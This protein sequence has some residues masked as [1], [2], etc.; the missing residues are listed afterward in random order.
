[1]ALYDIQALRRAICYVD[2]CHW[3]TL[4]SD[5][6]LFSP[7]LGPFHAGNCCVFLVHTIRML[8]TTEG[9]SVPNHLFHAVCFWNAVWCNEIILLFDTEC[10]F[11]PSMRP[12]KA[13]VLDSHSTAMFVLPYALRLGTQGSWQFSGSYSAQ[14]T[15]SLYYKSPRHLFRGFCHFLSL[16][17]PCYL[18][19]E[20]VKHR[21]PCQGHYQH[22]IVASSPSGPFIYPEVLGF[23]THPAERGGFG[24]ARRE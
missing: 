3:T 11:K 8:S 17:I 20:M 4:A 5:E 23:F 22:L 15:D 1:M 9:L 18:R 19:K 2:L 10:A 16:L 14:G 12:L 7:G 6:V 24:V 21:I 13:L